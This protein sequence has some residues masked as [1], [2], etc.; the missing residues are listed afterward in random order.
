MLALA[1]IF[2]D[3]INDIVDKNHVTDS[4]LASLQSLFGTTL[5][6][7]LEL[8][9]ND[10]VYRLNSTP[11]SRH[12]H[13]AYDFHDDRHFVV[14][15]SFCTCPTF[16]A[17]V[18]EKRQQISCKH[19]LAVKISDALGKTK[20]ILVSEDTLAQIFANDGCYSKES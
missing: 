18:I 17:D 19:E 11:P 4:T 5:L 7:A 14:L 3:L 9:D 15:R 8:V 12:A 20:A 1:P 16:S 6:S 13:M 2:E 10:A